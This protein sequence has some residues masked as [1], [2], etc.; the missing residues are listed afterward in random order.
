MIGGFFSSL[1]TILLIIY[2]ALCV[3]KIVT[4]DENVKYS[5][6]MTLDLEELGQVSYNDETD[7]V[8]FA[9]IRKDGIGAATPYINGSGNFSQYVNVYFTQV[10]ANYYIPK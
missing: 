2:F 1:I 5:T 9:I 6:L 4:G 3:K 10:I 7:L 8:M